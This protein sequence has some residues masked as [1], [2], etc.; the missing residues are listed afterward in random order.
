MAALSV[1]NFQEA[2]PSALSLFSLPPY[3]SAVERMYFQEVRSNSQLTGN[4]IDMEN[5]VWNMS[6]SRDQS[7][8]SKQK[9]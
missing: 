9:S 1:D 4:I 5:T 8:T 7:S 6:T 2:Q 3:Q